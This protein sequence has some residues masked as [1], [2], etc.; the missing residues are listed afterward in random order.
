[1]ANT[2]S[3]TAAIP[4]TSTAVALAAPATA[5]TLVNKSSIATLFF[6]VENIPATISQFGIDPGDLYQYCGKNPV[7]IITII[8]SSASGNYSLFANS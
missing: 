7:S 5:F 8:G 4:A 1:M 6:N 3:I 2:T